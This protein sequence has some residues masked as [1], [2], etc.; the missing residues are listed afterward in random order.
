MKIA[1]VKAGMSGISVVAKLVDKSEPRE[2]MTRYGRRR[3]AD[4]VLEDETGQI[5]LS[6][7]GPQIGKVRVG[8]KVSIEGAFVRTFRDRLILNIPTSGKLEVVERTQV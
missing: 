3:V 8:D 7:W 6:L 2:V 5:G 1:D 4:A